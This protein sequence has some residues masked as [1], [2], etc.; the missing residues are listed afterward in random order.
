MPGFASPQR[1]LVIIL[2]RRA[3]ADTVGPPRQDLARSES[4]GVL[5]N[6][7]ANRAEYSSSSQRRAEG[8]ERARRPLPERALLLADEPPQVVQMREGRLVLVLS[9]AEPPQAGADAIA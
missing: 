6:L 7:A 1:E 2:K 5:E 8:G 3:V 4:G 9:D